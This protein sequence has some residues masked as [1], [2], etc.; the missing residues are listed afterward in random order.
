M[1]L[2][3]LLQKR[4]AITMLK[5]SNSVIDKISERSESSWNIQVRLAH[6][7]GSVIDKSPS[8]KS[9]DKLIGSIYR[10]SIPIR[11]DF[12]LFQLLPSV[13]CIYLFV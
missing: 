11:I 12:R 8:A 9:G 10:K 7:R 13:H 2:M 5:L 4:V 6:S 1:K 3:N